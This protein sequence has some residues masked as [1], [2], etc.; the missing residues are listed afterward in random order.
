[1]PAVAIP[2]T[3]L[4]TMFP[5]FSGKMNKEMESQLRPVAKKL[6]DDALSNNLDVEAVLN[7]DFI[8]GHQ[9]NLTVDS[10]KSQLI[11]MALLTTYRLQNLF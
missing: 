2:L 8:I 5:D 1:M 9:L 10:E 11:V 7:K 4:E 3:F 6:L